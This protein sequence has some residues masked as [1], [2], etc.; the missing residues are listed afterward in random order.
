MSCLMSPLIDFVFCFRQ[1]GGEHYFYCFGLYPFVDSLFQTKWGEKF[2]VL[3]FTP[4]LLIDKKGEKDFEFIHAYLSFCIYWVLC[5][6]CF[7]K[8]K[9]REKFVDCVFTPLLMIDKKGEKDFEFLYMHIYGFAYIKFNW[10]LEHVYLFLKI[11]LENFI[12]I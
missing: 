4:L 12:G 8:Q 1:K 3:A 11:S 7:H 5:I 10:Y 6:L 2:I 9:G